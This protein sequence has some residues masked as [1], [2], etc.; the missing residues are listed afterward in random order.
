MKVLFNYEK[1]NPIID[2]IGEILTDA[3]MTHFEVANISL[4]FVEIVLKE[5]SLE[6]RRAMW[7]SINRNMREALGLSEVAPR[8]DPS[9]QAFFDRQEAKKK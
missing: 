6:N 3:K 2:K 1:I 7:E 4:H 8:I 9:V 5:E